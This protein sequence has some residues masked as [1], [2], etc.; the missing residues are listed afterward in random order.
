M[1]D[2]I[3]QPSHYTQ[4][5]IECIDYIKDILSPEE[6]RGYLRG[7]IAKY[8]HRFVQKNGVQDLQKAQVYL[9]WLI[10]EMSND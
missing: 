5:K 9:N 6:Y 7:N 2:V 1:T 8:M 3:K 4:G 10:E